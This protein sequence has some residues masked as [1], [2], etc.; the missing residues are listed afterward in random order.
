MFRAVAHIWPRLDE[1][2]GW[3]DLIVSCES[4]MLI[5][6]DDLDIAL[7]AHGERRLTQ[8]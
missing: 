2:Q 4:R 1:R 6:I 8:A 5:D 7:A 3:N